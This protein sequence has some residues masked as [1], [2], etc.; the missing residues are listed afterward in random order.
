METEA[1]RVF[2]EKARGLEFTDA[3]AAI[4][5]VKFGWV[6]L[7]TSGSVGLGLGFFLNLGE[8]LTFFKWAICCCC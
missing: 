2:L 4:S 3:W 6:D 7:V 1:F 5:D 8:F